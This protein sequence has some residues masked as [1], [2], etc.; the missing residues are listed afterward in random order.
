[1]DKRQKEEETVRRQYQKGQACQ[2]IFGSSER[3]AKIE[4]NKK[5]NGQQNETR[6][7]DQL[8]DHD[9]SNSSVQSV[10]D[11]MHQKRFVTKN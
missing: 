3:A 4:K 2:K 6:E 8:Q 11:G 10:T 9:K 7:E 5:W 1:M